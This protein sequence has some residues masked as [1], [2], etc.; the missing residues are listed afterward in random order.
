MAKPELPEF[1][2]LDGEGWNNP[3]TGKHEYFLLLCSN[4]KYIVNTE[5][6]GIPTRTCFDFL[7][8]LAEQN[9]GKTF[10]SFYFSYDVNMMMIDVPDFL[11]KMLGTNTVVYL[12]TGY[13]GSEGYKIHYVP[14]KFFTLEQGYTDDSGET[15]KWVCQR[16]ITVYD[17]WGFFQTSF[18]GAIHQFE[19]GTKAERDLITST[20]LERSE[21][22]INDIERITDY[23]LLECQLLVKVMDKLAVALWDSGLY[24]S[25]WHGSGAVGES[26]LTSKN[27]RQTL[28]RP[29]D[30]DLEHAIR[31]AYFG[32]RIQSLIAGHLF[33]PIYQYDI[34]SAYPWGMSNLPNLNNCYTIRVDQYVPECATALYLV[35]WDIRG[36]GDIGPFPFRDNDKGIYYPLKGKGWYWDYEV[37]ACQYAYGD[38]FKVLDGYLFQSRYDDIPFSW[39]NEVFKERKRLKDSGDFS[40]I[41]LKLALNSIYGKMAQRGFNGSV[42]R[43]QCHAYAG[44]IT[45]QCR[46]SVFKL[47][48]QY[49]DDCIAFSTDGVFFRRNKPYCTVGSNLGEWELT[50]YTDGLFIMP[51]VYFLNGDKKTDKSRGFSVKSVERQRMFDEWYMND[52]NGS[53]MIPIKMFVGMK[54]FTDKHPWRSWYEDAKELSFWPSRGYPEMIDEI[55][56]TYRI[57]AVSE[58]PGTS[59][60]YAGNDGVKPVTRPMAMDAFDENIKKLF[61]ELGL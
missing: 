31:S 25:R 6:G 30:V 56:P 51:G 7:L 29:D 8:D 23:C 20:K 37:K 22:D 27:V 4:G 9:R 60:S 52:I 15:P 17:V 26:L 46:S 58:I 50:E 49:P 11:G 48:M 35:E 13:V 14:K 19:V 41:A 24:I 40:Q 42:P 21:F 28:Y 3:E 12:Y 47:A 5:T 34:V 61:D 1:L 2:S 45:S 36:I 55:N 43:F 32:G 44:M 16:S 18:V 59:L 39:I 57:K 54:A 53:V 33:E 10:V 38:A